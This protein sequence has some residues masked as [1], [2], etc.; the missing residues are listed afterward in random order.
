MI[1]RVYLSPGDQLHE[2][3]AVLVSDQLHGQLLAGR[4]LVHA[5]APSRAAAAGGGG[6]GRQQDGL[7]LGGDLCWPDRDMTGDPTKAGRKKKK[8]II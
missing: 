2:G 3:P 1:K 7:W 5:V 6:R 4:Q 8:V